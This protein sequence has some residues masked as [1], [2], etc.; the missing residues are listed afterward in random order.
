MQRHCTP[1]QHDIELHQK[2]LRINLEMVHI[3]GPGTEAILEADTLLAL[4][5]IVDI[6]VYNGP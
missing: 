5:L 4:S 3:L 1:L 2:D 6:W